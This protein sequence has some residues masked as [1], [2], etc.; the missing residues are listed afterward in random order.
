MTVRNG[1]GA[2]PSQRS[3]TTNH[4][5]QR[6]PS[7]QQVEQRINRAWAS[8]LEKHT[9]S[10]MLPEGMGTLR[11]PEPQRLAYYGGLAAL[12]LFGVLDWPIVMVLGVGHLLAERHHHQ[13]LHDF[14]EALAEA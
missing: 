8:T 6:G 9:V 10:L 11:L 12:G 2:E 13:C 5:S 1:T 7:R 14:G 4:S 3:R